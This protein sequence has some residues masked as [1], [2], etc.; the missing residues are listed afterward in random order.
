MSRKLFH[1]NILNA[2]LEE[3]QKWKDHNAHK[4]VDRENLHFITLRWV[5]PIRL[6]MGKLKL[7]LKDSHTRSKENIY[8]NI[9]TSFP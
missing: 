1:C 6:Q 4:T 9:I 7:I 5:N 3:L 8:S 2:K